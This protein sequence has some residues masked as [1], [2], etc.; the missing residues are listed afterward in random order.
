[1]TGLDVDVTRVCATGTPSVNVP[2]PNQNRETYATVPSQKL[3]FL[4]RTL[5][6]GNAALLR[7]VNASSESSFKSSG[8]RN[9]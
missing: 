3:D 5:C 4:T 1:M 8:A 9:S 6:L 2:P 7:T